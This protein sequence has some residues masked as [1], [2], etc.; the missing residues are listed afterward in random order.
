MQ[1][2]IV[3]KKEKLLFHHQRYYSEKTVPCVLNSEKR[4]MM[5]M[6]SGVCLMFERRSVLNRV[7]DSRGSNSLVIFVG[8]TR[9]SFFWVILL[10]QTLGSDLLGIWGSVEIAWEVPNGFI[11]SEEI[12]SLPVNYRYKAIEKNSVLSKRR[13]R[14]TFCLQALN[15]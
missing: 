9:W 8:Q 1:W 15:F 10:D 14:I 6:M 3:I 5:I 7:G 2:L 11:T 13:H 12:S 4:M